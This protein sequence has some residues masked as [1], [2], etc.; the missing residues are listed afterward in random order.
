MADITVTPNRVR[1]L[2]SSQR[3]T[4]NTRAGEAIVRGQLVYEATDGTAK[5]AR[6]DA[7]ATAKVSGVALNDAA[8]GEPV[9]T[10]RYVFLAMDGLST[11]QPSTTLY[12]S[13]A[14]KGALAD[15]AATGTGKA[16][17]PVGVVRIMT[18][19]GNQKYVV[20]DIPQ[21]FVP[22]ALP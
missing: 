15:A 6:A 12:L 1:I 8:A 4:I 3:L 7:V 11:V 22:V 21:T 5:L 16:V 20:F 14:T 17:V 2:D 9:T 19:S 13:A 10:G 18:G